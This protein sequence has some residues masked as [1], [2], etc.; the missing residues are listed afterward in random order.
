MCHI[1]SDQRLLVP[2][3]EQRLHVPYSEQGPHVPCNEWS[4]VTCVI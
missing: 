1:V 2:Y 3:S 4:E